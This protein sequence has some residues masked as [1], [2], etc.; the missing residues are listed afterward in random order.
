MRLVRLQ[1]RTDRDESESAQRRGYPHES[2]R[3]RGEGLCCAA[4]LLLPPCFAVRFSMAR[5]RTTLQAKSEPTMQCHTPEVALLSAGG[6]FSS[7]CALMAVARSLCSLC[8]PKTSSS[9]LNVGR[10]VLR[11]VGLEDLDI[12]RHLR[13]LRRRRRLFLLLRA[14][15]AREEE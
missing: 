7:N 3:E 9:R 8:L 11:H 15:G 10:H 14:I 2:T 12:E 4:A 6:C 5:P 13:R 1:T